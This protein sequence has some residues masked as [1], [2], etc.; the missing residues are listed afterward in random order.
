MVQQVQTLE[1]A[2]LNEAILSKNADD[3]LLAFRDYALRNPALDEVYISR[4]IIALSCATHAT[5][6]GHFLLDRKALSEIPQRQA[7]TRAYIKTLL[8]I[9]PT[10]QPSHIPGP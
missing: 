9:N 7:E 3:I 8:P 2:T 4:T 6:V 10:G 1:E 5:A